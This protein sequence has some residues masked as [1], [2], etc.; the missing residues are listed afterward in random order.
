MKDRIYCECWKC[1]TLVMRLSVAADA[2]GCGEEREAE[3]E[4]PTSSSTVAGEGETQ[5]G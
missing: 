5:D 4:E 1:A 3:G 2:P